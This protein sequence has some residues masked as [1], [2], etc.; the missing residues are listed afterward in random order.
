LLLIQVIASAA[1]DTWRE[2]RRELGRMRPS[3]AWRGRGLCRAAA[4]CTAPV[5][6]AVLL[7]VPPR[8]VPGGAERREAVA[9]V[10]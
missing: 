4:G 5:T 9:F 10:A 8:Q 6:Q 3:W 7:G 2:I 1:C